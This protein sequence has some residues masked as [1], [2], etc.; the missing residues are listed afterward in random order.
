MSEVNVPSELKVA[1]LTAGRDRPYAFGMATALMAKGLSL[2]IIGGDDLDCSEW[3]GATHVRFLNLR[4]DMREDASLPKKISRVLIYYVRLIFYAAT[5][6]PKI[7]HILWNNKFE[8][9]DR[10]PL[11]LY[12]KILGKKTLLTVHNVNSRTRDS[13]D[14]WF[15]R[16]TLKVQYRLVDHLFVHTEK[17]KRELVE[18]FDVPASAISVIPFGINNAVPQTNLSSGEARQR[19][20][21]AEKDRAIL[22]FGNIAPYKG[23]EYLIDAFEQAMAGG[24]AYR[25]IIAGNPKNC[26]SYWNVV[27]ESLNRHVNRERIL[28]MIEYIPDDQTEVY[29]KAA[30]VLVL[31]YRYIYQSG[32]LFLGYSFGLP[33]IAA[34]VGALREDIIEGK[35]GYVCRPEDAA[36]MAKAIERY[37]ASDL[38]KNLNSRRQEIREYAH[39]RYSWNIVGEL[40]K[41]V[42]KNLLG[43]RPPTVDCQVVPR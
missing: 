13:N 18:Q 20:G 9:F 35:T 4:G 31:P 11:I 21:I 14:T 16:L 28:R 33:V 34:D 12:Y 10:V 30:D 38:F 26:E 7:F 39:E 37:F 42:Y 36:D 29:F 43:D 8:T 25:L 15:N 27:L 3:Q 22:F 40:T 17:M 2:D 41:N 32:V 19:L 24:G 6:E 1:L 23:L 5:A